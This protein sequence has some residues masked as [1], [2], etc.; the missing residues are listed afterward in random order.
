MKLT[1]YLMVAVSALLLTACNSDEF[2]TDGGVTV[3]MT[4]A[5]MKVKENAGIFNVPLTLKVKTNGPVEVTVNV[6]EYSESPAK[7][8]V[9]YLV[10]SYTVVF[11]ND[12]ASVGIEIAPTND[13]EINDD[14]L[15]IVSISKVQGAQIGEQNS[16]VVTIRDDDGMFYEAIQGN[17]TMK[18]INWFDDSEESFTLNITGV[19]ED[20]PNYEKTLYISGWGGFSG[21]NLM[22]VQ[23][24][25]YEDPATGE[26]TISIP[27]DQFMGTY[28]GAYEVYFYGVVDGY[29]E[30][31]GALVGT[32][33]ADLRTISFDPDDTVILYAAQNGQWVGGLDAYYNMQI[34]R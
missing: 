10:T 21:S 9:H 8:N 27:Y 29:L 11:P 16:T 22:T 14:R 23:A 1:K 4:Y 18:E 31:E 20:D 12:S 6:A 28:G 2:N 33:S 15:F 32:L 25:Y 34:S 19:D 24:E 17:W 7:E 3:E 26:I 30:D 13:M 5:T